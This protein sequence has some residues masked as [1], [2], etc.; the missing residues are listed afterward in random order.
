MRRRIFHNVRTYL[1]ALAIIGVVVTLVA[2]IFFTQGNLPWIAFLSGILAA[3][4]LADAAR[5]SRSEWVLMRR[6]AQ[7][8]AMKE[9]FEH[10]SGMLRIAEQKISDDDHR[11]RLL[12]DTLSTMIALI[13]ADGRCQ[14]H[15]RAFREWLHLNSALIDGRPLRELFGSKAYA[16]MATAVQQSLDGQA[17]R[18]EHLQ[19]MPGRVVYR[20]SVE[21][22]PLC[23]ASGKVSGFYWLADDI[24]QRDDLTLT[25]SR[26][27]KALS[28]AHDSKKKSV[29][30]GK[31]SG[32]VEAGIQF[33]SAIERGEFCLFC[34]LISPLSAAPG[35]TA[36]YEILIRL[37]EEEGAMIPPGAFFSLAEKHGL[38][39]YLDRWV[40]EHVLRWAVTQTGRDKDSI[41]FINMAQT[42]INDPAFPEFLLS[43]LDESG[44]PGSLLCFE[45]PETTLLAAGSHAAEFIRQVRQCG[46][47]VALSG[48]GRNTIDEIRGL[49]VEFLKLDGSM[50]LNMLNNPADLARVISIDRTAK[51]ISVKTVAELVESEE[52]VAKLKEIG[53]DYAQGFGI[54]RPSRLDE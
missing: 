29:L 32:R 47:R 51:K 37:I 28:T 11:L 53:I 19:E 10:E 4:V 3:S 45:V 38:M 30:S 48:F 1:V 34:Q 12:D 14:Y 36:H 20:L 15:N 6:T 39:P 5:A 27:K 50:I 13:G 8:A 44:M 7:L 52:I 49:Q 26:V 35:N 33:I 43:A 41:F 31:S 24:T 16:G 23:D 17:L 46:C 22:V 25:E 21:H 54:S 40:V 2:T 9:K 42:T 18:Y